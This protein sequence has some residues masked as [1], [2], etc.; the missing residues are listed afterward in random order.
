M[1]EQATNKRWSLWPQ[2]SA[3]K[4]WCWLSFWSVVVVVCVAVVGWVWV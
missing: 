2:V 1:L 3:E 4:S